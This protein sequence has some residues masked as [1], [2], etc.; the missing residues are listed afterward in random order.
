M[1]SEGTI[2]IPEKERQQVY[3]YV[4]ALKDFLTPIFATKPVPAMPLIRELNSE[5]SPK[6]NQKIAKNLLGISYE[7]DKNKRAGSY[8]NDWQRI[9]L[10]LFYLGYARAGAGGSI[11]LS[12]VNYD[13][14]TAVLMHEVAH[15]KQ[16]MKLRSRQYGRT[17]LHT[18]PKD[19]AAYFKNP[20]EQHA[21]AVGYLE[22]LKARMKTSSPMEILT[23]L[24]Q[25]GLLHDPAI[26]ALK[27]SDY[28]TWKAIMKHA[29]MTALHDLER[30][31]P[32]KST[33]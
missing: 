1:L 15:Y 30:E 25:V 27:D 4:A 20:I 31:K 33:A 6:W 19:L 10:N 7:Y 9:S 16:D 18:E 17:L 13:E 26:H 11:L 21:W 5:F 8:S 32:K 28:D 14:L 12:G 29:V 24:R 3:A 23:K 2:I 22:K